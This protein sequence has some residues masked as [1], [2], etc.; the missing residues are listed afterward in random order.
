MTKS[1]VRRI[2]GNVGQRLDIESDCTASSGL[3]PQSSIHVESKMH[4]FDQPTRSPSVNCSYAA[5]GFKSTR[6]DAVTQS[7]SQYWHQANAGRQG[8]T[9]SLE[10]SLRLDAG[11]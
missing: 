11:S 10:L 2:D 7:F 6:F 3:P 1:A 9:R 8:L 4:P 5:L